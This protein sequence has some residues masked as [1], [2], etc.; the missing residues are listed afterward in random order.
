MKND[1][2]AAIDGV[3][4]KQLI[5]NKITLWRNTIY[6]AELDARVADAL[7]KEAASEQ[8]QERMK[9]AMQAVELLEGMLD[10]LEREAE[11]P[12]RSKNQT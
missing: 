2:G 11:K 12:V 10:E 3:A 5:E 6:D 4:R 9:E 7:G 8:A 1:N